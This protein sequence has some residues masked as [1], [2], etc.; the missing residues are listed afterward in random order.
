[1]VNAF[2]KSVI[3]AEVGGRIS[4]R[5]VEPGQS[6]IAGQVL[7]RLDDERLRMGVEVAAAQAQSRQVDLDQAEHDLRKGRRLIERN[8]ISQDILDDFGF[9]FNRARSNLAAAQAQLASAR[10]E[11]ADTMIRA[12]FSGT[13]EVVHVEQGDYL[14]PGAPVVTIA[15]FSKVRV[16]AGVTAADANYLTLGDAAKIR[17]Q[18]LGGVELGGQIHSVGR[19]ADAS[20]TFPVEIWVEDNQAQRLREGMVAIVFLP[21]LHSDPLPTV[22]R[23]S[24]LRRDGE[25]F[26]YVLKQETAALRAIS[27]GRSNAEFTEVLKGIELG[28]RVVV[29]GMFALRDGANVEVVP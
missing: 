26:V 10:R 28:E 13:A 20:G 23:A 3:S 22:P 7:V 6:V 12:A 19:I 4:R 21:G 8:V 27:L 5:L 11:L 29:D 1:V 24:V 9:A 2:R 15:D 17:L 16:R 18:A 25:M 14:V